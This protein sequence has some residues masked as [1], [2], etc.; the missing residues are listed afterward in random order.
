MKSLEWTD[1]QLAVFWAYYA[2]RRQEDYFTRLF[3]D[4]ILEQTRRF[5]GR[6]ALVCDYGC[7]AGYLL[8]KLL[9]THRAAGCDFSSDNLAEVRK[10]LGSNPNL[11]ALFRVGEQAQNLRCDAAYVV[12]T[13]EH[14]LER[15]EEQFFGNLHALL[16]P[17]GVVVVTTPNA[18]DLAAETVFCPSCRHGF[19]RWQHVR[20]FDEAGLREFFGRRGFE[21]VACFTTDFAAGTPW[22]RLKARLRA[23]LG[24]KNPHLVYA[25]RKRAQ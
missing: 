6:D 1:E 3:G 18:E 12:E 19:H 20:S 15:H 25:G 10:R 22:R 4:R 16:K 23:A 24:R 9:A 7:G 14:V 11:A 21:Q 13:V 2:E 17:G 5:Y 8:E